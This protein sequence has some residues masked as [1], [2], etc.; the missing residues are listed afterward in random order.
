MP[1][2]KVCPHG[3]TP[4]SNC[5][6]CEREFQ[7]Q[8]RLKH[9][10]K[11]KAYEKIYRRE[12][13]VANRTLQLLD[14]LNRRAKKLGAEG[15][16]TP[17]YYDSIINNPCVYCGQSGL[18]MELDHRIPISQGGTNWPENVQAICRYCNKAKHWYGEAD[19]LRWLE[20]ARRKAG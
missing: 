10:E 8:Y 12:Y 2:K 6:P 15:V 7:K 13:Y 11:L 4:K 19:F 17:E 14:S 9:V 20:G 18:P 5:A 3:I 16:I 1:G